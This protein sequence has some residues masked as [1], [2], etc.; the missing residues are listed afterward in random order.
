MNNEFFSKIT[1]F[2]YILFYLIYF[3]WNYLIMSDDENS[4]N[5]M[6]NLKNLYETQ[7][8]PLNYSSREGCFSIVNIG[9][10]NNIHSIK[11]FPNNSLVK[12]SYLSKKTNRTE[13]NIIENDEQTINT[14]NRFYNEIL[15]NQKLFYN[16]EKIKNL[17]IYDNYKQLLNKITSNKLFNIIESPYGIPMEEIE[18]LYNEYDFLR[19]IEK[20]QISPNLK[21]E[22][23]NIQPNSIFQKIFK[24]IEEKKINN[25]NIIFIGEN[26][27][28]KSY[29]IYLTIFLLRLNP[30]NFII[31]ILD[32]EKFIQNPSDYILNEIIFY[33]SN[34]YYNKHDT[35]KIKKILEKL[36]SLKDE[37]KTYEKILDFFSNIY[38]ELFNNLNLN[39]NIY[40]FIDSY[41]NI[42]KKREINSI[43]KMLEKL[44]QNANGFLNKNFDSHY[45][46]IKII[47][48]DTMESNELIKENIE[49]IK[50]I[51]KFDNQIFM[52]GMIFLKTSIINHNEIS[53]YIK[54]KFKTNFVPNID[55][56][57]STIDFY[58]NSNFEK[59]EA[60][61]FDIIVNNYETE[62]FNKICK[63]LIKENQQEYFHLILNIFAYKTIKNFQGIPSF[64]YF[65]GKYKNYY[66]FFLIPIY[67]NNNIKFEYKNKIIENFISDFKFEN[68]YKLVN[69][70][71][72]DLNYFTKLYNITDFLVLK[73]I[74]LE[75]ILYLMFKKNGEEKTINLKINYFAKDENDVSYKKDLKLN[76]PKVE[77]SQNK[78][79]DIFERENLF[80]SEVD[81]NRDGFYFF[82][83]KF[84][85]IDAVII[86]YPDLYFIQI[87]KTLKYEYLYQINKDF[88]LFYL[89]MEN[90]VVYKELLKNNDIIYRNNNQIN[91][92][93]NF[94]LKIV[95]YM[96]KNPK[97]K[98]YYMFLYK[99]EE[100]SRKFDRDYNEITILD[101]FKQNKEKIETTKIDSWSIKDTIKDKYKYSFNEKK[102]YIFCNKVKKNIILCKMEEFIREISNDELKYYF[103]ELHD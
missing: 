23:I 90:N 100:Y 32:H 96:K 62:F 26:G 78:K 88:H 27:I 76:I 6:D 41:E 89:M 4:F 97:L 52:N 39:I 15:N 93:L 68:Y 92:K 33:I 44:K 18:M 99:D 19:Y 42:R 81:L 80:S 102:L 10:L 8:F 17:L 69:L 91:T 58:E 72:F 48:S 103:S 14:N 73:G 61:A 31:S 30:F 25:N 82:S 51:I 64:S 79:N 53:Y 34:L 84:P 57:Y 5:G 54:S 49:E 63:S 47:S 86:N 77:K 20:K 9:Q 66:Y 38:N 74:L 22:I 7:I 83:H 36:I 71:L 24:S 65:N 85:I 55:K 95:N 40:L 12:I 45:K 70:S 60:K 16:N 46:I 98:I 59:N 50:Q 101:E 28:G 56:N 94:W 67:E 37:E 13:Q 21:N 1:F 43:I 11:F 29:S 75:E 35:N 87:K 3:Y 2:Y